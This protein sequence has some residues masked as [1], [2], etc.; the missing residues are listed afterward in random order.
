M[1]LDWQAHFSMAT[2]IPVQTGSGRL[3]APAA[4]GPQ[5]ALGAQ[6]MSG[7]GS[8]SGSLQPGHAGEPSQ[9]AVNGAHFPEGADPRNAAGNSLNLSAACSRMPVGLTVAVPIRD[10]RVRQLLALAAGAVVK[11]TWSHGEDLPLTA[12][13]VQLAWSEFE[14]VDVRLAVRVTRLA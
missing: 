8:S 13:N 10:F 4:I 3:G 9:L 14:V 6:M 5:A 2:Q 1:L 11:T 7:S 12:G